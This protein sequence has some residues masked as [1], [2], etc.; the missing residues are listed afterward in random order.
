MRSSAEKALLAKLCS[1][2]KNQELFA[3]FLEDLL[4][5]QEFTELASRWQLV[6]LLNAGMT[7][8]EIAKKLGISLS[9]ITRGSRE[10][11]DPKGGFRRALNQKN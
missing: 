2:A 3:D 5:P 8:R 9:K 7:Q 1:L 4:T 6:Q 11:L 10:L